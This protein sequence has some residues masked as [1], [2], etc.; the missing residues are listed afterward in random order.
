MQHPVSLRTFRSLL[1]GA[2]MGVAVCAGVAEVTMKPRIVDLDTFEVVGIMAS[3][4]N[5]KEASPDGIIGKQ[6]QQFVAERLA[7]K[8]P[9]RLDHDILAVY[10]D[11]VSDANGQYTYILGA[12]VKPV[13]NPAVPQGMVVKAIP[14]GRYA[15]FTS[16]R[17][18]VAKVVVETWKQIWSYYQSPQNGTRAYVADFEVYD[19]RASDPNTS[20]VDIYIGVK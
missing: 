14:A 8:I 20:Q 17:G 13:V 11:Y 3:T 12:R 18:P 1:A 4:N 10:A 5:A 15:V 2:T 7:D 16:E 9:D 19:E 6:W